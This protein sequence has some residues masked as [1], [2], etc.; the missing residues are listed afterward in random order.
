[1][2]YLPVKYKPGMHFLDN[3]LIGNDGRL[4]MVVRGDRECTLN[5]L[6]SYRPTSRYLPSMFDLTTLSMAGFIL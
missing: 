3:L 5:L 1:M 6:E 2:R 4:R